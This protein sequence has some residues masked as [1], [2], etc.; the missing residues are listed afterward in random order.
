MKTI[1]K[2]TNVIN[3]NNVNEMELMRIFNAK[4]FKI[5]LYLEKKPIEGV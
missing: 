5:I 4:L 3:S 1:Y 2:V